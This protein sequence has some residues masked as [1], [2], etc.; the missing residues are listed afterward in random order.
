MVTVRP[1]ALTMPDVTVLV[2]SRGA[3]SATTGSPTCTEPDDPNGM[4]DSDEAMLTLIKT[5]AHEQPVT[6]RLQ[7]DFLF[8]GDSHL[9]VNAQQMAVA[10]SII[11]A[12]NEL[13]TFLN[14]C[15]T[16]CDLVPSTLL[17]TSLLT[18]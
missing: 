18:W 11:D 7:N 9:K 6:L 13:K 10:T 8:L 14:Y 16:R 3:P 17:P 2:R 1:T 4:G 15:R 12:L 5:M